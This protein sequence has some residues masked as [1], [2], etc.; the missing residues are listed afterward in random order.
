MNKELEVMLLGLSK[1][2]GI[3]IDLLWSAL[4]KQA[5]IE[6]ATDI[7]FYILGGLALVGAA[8]ALRAANKFWDLGVE[9]CFAV[10]VA[11]IS[12]AILA[13][14]YTVSIPF[15]IHEAMTALC[16]PEYWALKDILCRF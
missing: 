7:I 12:L 5:Y 16:N 6:G 13:F 15:C 4:I 9:N 8:M 11:W 2:L 1:K 10:R 3:S 14:L